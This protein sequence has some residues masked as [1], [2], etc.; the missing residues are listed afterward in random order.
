MAKGSAALCILPGCLR[1]E[2]SGWGLVSAR[3]GPGSEGRWRGEQGIFLLSFHLGMSTIQ[4]RNAVD[5]RRQGPRFTGLTL[6]T[7]CGHGGQPAGGPAVARFRGWGLSILATQPPGPMVH[8]SAAAWVQSREAARC[9]LGWGETPGWGGNSLVRGPR[10]DPP[11]Q[12]Y[13]CLGPR[14]EC[15]REMG[16]ALIVCRGNK[17]EG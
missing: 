12:T 9:G 13:Q 1:N 15:L 3:L 5:A 11:A 2:S 10:T 16:L 8:A 7:N 14:V 4:R 6:A 17:S